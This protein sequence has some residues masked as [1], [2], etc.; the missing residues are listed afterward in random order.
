MRPEL[1]LYLI[2]PGWMKVEVSKCKNLMN[3]SSLTLHQ[4]DINFQQMPD[5]AMP[6]HVYCSPD[7][8]LRKVDK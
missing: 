3:I 6:S 4:F 1:K 5:L 8:L 7:F 2:K